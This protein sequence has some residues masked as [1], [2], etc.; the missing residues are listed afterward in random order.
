MYLNAPGPMIICYIGVNGDFHVKIHE[1]AYFWGTLQ[2]SEYLDACT[3]RARASKNRKISKSPKMGSNTPKLSYNSILK[4]YE[5][6][7]VP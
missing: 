3:S 4:G 6:V 5:P 1:I 7:V 2:Y